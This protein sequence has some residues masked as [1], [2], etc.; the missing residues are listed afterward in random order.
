[1]IICDKINVR[2]DRLLDGLIPVVQIMAQIEASKEQNVM[3]FEAMFES[4][5]S[6]CNCHFMTKPQFL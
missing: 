1:M 2:D 5:E 4:K 3:I 6:N